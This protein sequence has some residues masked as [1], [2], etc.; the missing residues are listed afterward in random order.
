ME[1][2]SRLTN[3]LSQSHDSMMRQMSQHA[4]ALRLHV[5]TRTAGF[6]QAVEAPLQHVVQASTTAADMASEL[7]S[8]YAGMQE[9]LER[10]FN[11]PTS[12]RHAS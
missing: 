1:S 3:E 6:A 11:A 8:R 5:D 10:T 9:D 7:A 2:S 12:A 4:D